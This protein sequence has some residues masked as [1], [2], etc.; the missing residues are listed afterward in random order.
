MKKKNIV[1]IIIGLIIILL[2]MFCPLLKIH[3]IA[4]R[5]I[6]GLLGCFS[7][8]SGIYKAAQKN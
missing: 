5:I 2:V 3:S 7:F 6:I 1:L 8:V 4:W